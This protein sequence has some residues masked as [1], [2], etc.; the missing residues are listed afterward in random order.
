MIFGSDDKVTQNEKEILIKSQKISRWSAQKLY[1]SF[2][3]KNQRRWTVKRGKV[4][5]VDLGENIGSEEN[6]VRPVVV[7]QSNSYNFNSPVF[8]V[9][10]ISSGS[11]TIPDLQIEIINKYPYNED[12]DN[13]KVLCGA[14]DLGQIKTIGKERIVS[15]KL[16]ILKD[17]MKEVDKKILNIF[18][19]SDML[20]KK[21]NIIDS[22]NGKVDYLKEQLLMYKGNK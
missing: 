10:I 14:I 18:G 2:E 7:I 22:L 19:L 13:T 11:I 5:F 9:A 17:E 15:N 8:I 3:K 16:C 20:K 1:Y 4:Y 21:D 12:N 6:K